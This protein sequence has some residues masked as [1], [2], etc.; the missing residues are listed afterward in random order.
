MTTRRI[1]PAVRTAAADLARDER[2]KPDPRQTALITAR[3]HVGAARDDLRTALNNRTVAQ[4]APLS[5]AWP[6][7]P[8]DA[9]PPQRSGPKR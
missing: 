3:R 2:A 9:L 5:A 1:A 4:A 6:A 7:H 8:R